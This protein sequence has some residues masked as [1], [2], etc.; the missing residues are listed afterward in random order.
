MHRLSRIVLTLALAMSALGISALGAQ[1]RAHP[2]LPKLILVKSGQTTLTPSAATVKFLTS[3]AITVTALAPVSIQNGSLVLP[4]RKGVATRQ[5]R[6]VL[7]HRGG[8]E[9]ATGARTVKLRAITLYRFAKATFIGA[10]VNGHVAKR[11]ARVTGIKL[12]R[13]GNQ[14]TL[15]GE[16]HLSASAAKMINHLLGKHLVS[17]GYD[18]ARLSSQL[19]LA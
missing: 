18:L 15:T 19:T 1:A 2:A 12:T 4:V 16:V 11:L 10:L 17:A 14:A 6:G 9:F 3:H 13:T 7:L 5:L 8:V